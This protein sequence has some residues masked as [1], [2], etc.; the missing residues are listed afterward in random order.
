VS[1]YSA[2]HSVAA[3]LR[4]IVGP[5]GVVSQPD[6]LIV[7][8]CDGFTI[9]RAKPLA[10][11]FP[12]STD[13]VA[14]VV[15]LLRQKGL[16]IL[17][18]GSGT[19]L[20]GGIVAVTPGVQVSLARMNKILEIDVRNRCALVEAG[21]TNSALSDAVAA[22]PGGAGLHYAPDPSSQRASTIGGNVATNA[23]GL[24]TLKYGVTVNHVLGLEVVLEDGS[25]HALGGPGGGGHATG[26]DLVGLFCGTEGTLGIVTKVWCRLIPRPVAFRTALAIFDSTQKACQTVA[27]IIASGIIPAALEMMDGTM[28]GIVEEAF[29]LGFP[30]SAQA[31]LL[32]EVDGQELGL[33]EDLAQIEAICRKNAV[34]EFQGERDPKR[35][36]DLWSARKRAFGAIGRI[37]PSY[38]TQDACV[39]R[40]RLPEVLTRIAEICSKY[41]LRITNVFHA[42][43]GNVHPIL[44]YDEADEA[45]VRRALAASAEILRY[46]VSIGGS[47]TGEHGV[48]IEK[49]PYLRDMFSPEELESM[50]RI[51]R[52]FVS[53]DR[54]NPLKTLPREGVDIDLLHPSGGGRKVPQ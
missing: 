16:A 8:E 52:A 4:E 9:P 24:H 38:C 45:Q 23:G 10:V 44:M 15:K 43:D 11:V 22:R 3:V 13:Q 41:K 37:S 19:G 42:G 29:H 6:E 31:L 47:V 12:T 27:D 5:A 17:P 32:I 28:V 49:L 39:P 1:S 14:A 18:R 35:R 50:H 2:E 48:G 36:A 53:E 40:S 30:T 46:C 25:V 51:R 26:P 20:A 34:T 33:D 7:Y 54:M 21:V